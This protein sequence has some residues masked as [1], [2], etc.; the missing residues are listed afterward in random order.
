[1]YIA[2]P[3][4]AVLSLNSVLEFPLK[5]ISPNLQYTAQPQLA[6]LSLNTTMEFLIKDIVSR[7]PESPPQ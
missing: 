4:L 6:I 7:T 1:M 2:P 5:D 3:L